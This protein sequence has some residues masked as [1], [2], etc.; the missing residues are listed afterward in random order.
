[1]ADAPSNGVEPEAEP[2]ADE[3]TVSDRSLLRRLRAGQ[4]DAAT[5]LYL[6]YADRLHALAARQCGA[7]L[8][9][10]VDPED[11]VQSVFRTFFRRVARGDYDAPEGEELWKLFLVIALNKIRATGAYHRAAK[12]DVRATVLGPRFQATLETIPDKDHQAVLLLHMVIEEVLEGVPEVQRRMIELRISGHEV[13]DIARLTQRS[14]RS[15]ERVLRG[16]RD[17]L[18]TKVGAE[19]GNGG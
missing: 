9:S 19:N 17:E 11:I 12:R 15:V 1:M 4:R 3:R 6:R 7:D 18:S 14:K 2:A 16:F 10:R 5:T 13:A 8:A